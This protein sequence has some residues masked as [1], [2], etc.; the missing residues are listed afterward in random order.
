MKISENQS[1]NKCLSVSY[2]QTNIDFHTL[3]A[4]KYYFPLSKNKDAKDQRIPIE[5]QCF[6]SFPAI[7]PTK[8]MIKY[9]LYL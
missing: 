2:V 9:I 5:K 1:L 8:S 7:L 4:I 6:N 3:L